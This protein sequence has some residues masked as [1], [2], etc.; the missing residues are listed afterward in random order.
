[1]E[2]YHYWLAIYLK[3]FIV[4]EMV[5]SIGAMIHCHIL[6]DYFGLGMSTETKCSGAMDIFYQE[7]MFKLQSSNY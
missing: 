1:M 6:M 2:H 7:I 3:S 5:W 4:K